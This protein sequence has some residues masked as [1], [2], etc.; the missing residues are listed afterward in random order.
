MMHESTNIKS[1]AHT[2]TPFLLTEG[3]ILIHSYT[4]DGDIYHCKYY[5]EQN[6]KDNCMWKNAKIEQNEVATDLGWAKQDSVCNYTCDRHCDCAGF[7]TWPCY[8]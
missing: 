5:L 3:H 6:D 7:M 2:V 1:A 8:S 4:F